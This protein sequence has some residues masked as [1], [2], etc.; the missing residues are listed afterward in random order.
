MAWSQKH[1]AWLPVV[2][3]LFSVLACYGTL[4]IVA[5]LGA[6]GI[7]V[8]INDAVWAAV[9][10]GFASAA[11]LGLAASIRCHQRHWPL[12]MGLVGLAALIYAFYIDYHRMT[13]LV[14]L[15]LLIAAAAWDWHLRRRNS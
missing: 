6:L 5:A 4:V 14:G 9:I 1:L 10:V 3:T 8:A 12:A 11:V 13:E 15:A 2:S 7:A